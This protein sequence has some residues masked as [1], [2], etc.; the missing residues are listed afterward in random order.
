MKNSAIVED[1]TAPGVL[2][3]LLCGAG[4]VQDDL[5]EYAVGPAAYPEIQIVADL[6]G[7]DSGV[8]ALGG[9]NKMNTK[10]PTLPVD[11][12]KP[13]LDLPQAFLAASFNFISRSWATTAF[14][15]S[16]DACLLS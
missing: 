9:K 13:V 3:Y 2:G 15:F 5:R 14:A 12:G 4:V 10:G 11:C 7:D 6:T 16:L 8:R 1:E